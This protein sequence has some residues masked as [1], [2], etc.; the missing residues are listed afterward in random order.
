MVETSYFS[1]E[2]ATCLCQPWLEFSTFLV[3]EKVS[4][5]PI[6]LR[7]GFDCACNASFPSILFVV[8][9]FSFFV[10]FDIVFVFLSKIKNWYKI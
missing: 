5:W 10:F 6:V 9:D 2:A 1:S 7:L 4:C 8:L 3:V